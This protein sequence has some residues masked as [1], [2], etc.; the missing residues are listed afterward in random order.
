MSR[1]LMTSG[2]GRPEGMG[3]GAVYDSV[4]RSDDLRCI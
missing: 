3:M 1:A 4:T 2:T